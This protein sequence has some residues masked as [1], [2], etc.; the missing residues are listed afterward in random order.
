MASEEAKSEIAV[1]EVT[2]K[3][4]TMIE[5]RKEIEVCDHSRVEK[6]RPDET[7]NESFE[8][9]RTMAKLVFFLNFFCIYSDNNT[10]RSKSVRSFFYKKTPNCFVRNRC[11]VGM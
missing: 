2:E 5:Q 7:D 10:L 11:G 9:S 1:K 3:W 6:K 4:N 8:A